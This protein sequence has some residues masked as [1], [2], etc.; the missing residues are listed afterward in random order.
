MSVFQKVSGI[1]YKAD[2]CW[3]VEVYE[4]D[5]IVQEKCSHQP[6]D[7]H[8]DGIPECGAP[9]TCFYLG[10]GQTYRCDAHSKHIGQHRKHPLPK[11]QAIRA[12][13]L[14]PSGDKVTAVFE[15]RTASALVSQIERSGLV[16]SIGNAMWLGGE[17]V[18]AE[19]SK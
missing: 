15:G 12:V 4:T 5:E 16:T 3:K 18:K 10:D 7:E 13:C 1:E 8:D 2:E 19:I 17:L 6:F 9:A 14:T 11:V